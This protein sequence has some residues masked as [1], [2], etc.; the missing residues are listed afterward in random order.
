MEDYGVYLYLLSFCPILSGCQTQCRRSGKKPTLDEI[1][2]ARIQIFQ[3]SMFGNGL[4]EVMMIQLERYPARD[5]PWIQT[6][7]SEMVL[8]LGGATTEGIFRVPGDIDEVNALKMRMDRWLLPTVSDPHVPASLLKL[9]YRE[10]ADPLIPSAFYDQCLK[11]CDNATE[12]CRLVEQMP[13]INRIVLAY[14]IRF[15]QVCL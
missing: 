6:T 2:A 7:L 14:L 11:Y 13:R 5:L 15:L 3:P 12:A 1:E 4:E 8:Q 9:W 10:L